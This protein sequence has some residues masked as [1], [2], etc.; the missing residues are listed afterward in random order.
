MP[1]RSARSAPG[2]DRGDSR[3]LLRRTRDVAGIGAA[4]AGGPGDDGA[5]CAASGDGAGCSRRAP[6]RS[7]ISRRACSTR[8]S[9]S[10]PRR[11][12]RAPS[13]APTACRCRS[14]PR[15]RRSRISSTTSSRTGRATD[16][17]DRK[18]QSLGSGF[19]V[20]AEQG[21]VVTN[22]H[23]I[24]DADEIEVNFTDGS[25][26][27]AELVGTDTKTDIAVL[28]V[29]PKAAASSTAVQVRQFRRDAHRRL[30][31][32][33]RQSVRPRR[34]GHGRHRLGAQPRHQLRPL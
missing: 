29:D 25:K 21:I 26:L 23:V 34:H 30:G 22:N 13:R 18:V 33:D 19:V 17:G 14:F 5:T 11:P 31:D 8:W 10:R 12:S 2:A 3:A 16:G 1:V 7:P 32:G 6:R 28:K 15:A 9:T 24:A 4:A 27:K 20:D